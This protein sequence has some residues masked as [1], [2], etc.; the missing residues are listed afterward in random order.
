MKESHKIGI[1][2]IQIDKYENMD[3]GK[4]YDVN[5]SHLPVLWIQLLDFYSQS[6][7]FF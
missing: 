5:Y 3:L 6:P 4:A 2:S 7:I 1:L